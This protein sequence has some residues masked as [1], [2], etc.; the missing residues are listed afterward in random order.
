MTVP[1]ISEF[2][3]QKTE[4]K[5]KMKKKVTVSLANKSSVCCQTRDSC[6]CFF[7]KHFNQLSEQP[8]EHKPKQ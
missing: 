7:Y 4:K 3:F 5:K 8:K 1:L 2:P 6:S